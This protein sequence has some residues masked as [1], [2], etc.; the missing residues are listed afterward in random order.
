MCGTDLRQGGVF[1]YASLEERVPKNHPLRGMRT[2][3]DAALAELPS[4]RRYPE[5]TRGAMSSRR[6]AAPTVE[7]KPGHHGFLLY[8]AWVL[9]C[10]TVPRPLVHR[11]RVTGRVG[12]WCPGSG[13]R[14]ARR[15]W[16]IGAGGQSARP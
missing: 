4:P 11:R 13:L 14:R 2:M 15:Y 5:A 3:V 16:C 1:S 7:G 10:R 12:R 8:R 9:S 6:N